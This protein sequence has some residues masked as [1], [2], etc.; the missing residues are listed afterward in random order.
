[1]KKTLTFSPFARIEG[2]LR[3]ELEIRDGH[4]AE[5]KSSGHLFRGFEWMVQGRE[6]LE[7]LVILCRICGQCSLAHSATCA[8]AL[9]NI[10]GITPPP[11]GLLANNIASAIE[12]ILSHLLHFYTSFAP[13][14]AQPPYDPT[15]T[16]RFSLASGTSQREA[17]RMRHEFLSLMGFFAGKWPN[18]LA[19]Q[20]GGTTRP[21]DTT[22]LLR[23]AGILN[24]FRAALEEQVLRGPIAQWLEIDSAPAL[25]NWLVDKN[26]CDSDLGVFITLARKHGLD[27]L[28]VGPRRFISSGGWSMGP[29]KTWLR[30]GFLDAD[31]HAEFKPQEITEDC[32]YAWY[33]APS[34]ASPLQE[35]GDPDPNRTEAY[36][37]AKA[38][39]YE[40]KSAEVGPMARMLSDGDPLA[41]NLLSRFGPSVMLRVIMRW[42]EVFRLVE[43]V[44]KWISE[45]NPDEPFYVKER[46]WDS[47]STSAAGITEAPRG[48]LGHWVEVE[49]GRIRNYQ[50]ITPTGWNFSPRDSLSNPGPLEEALV[51]T[52]INDEENP[53]TVSHVVRSFDPCLF[54]M[55]H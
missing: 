2:Q 45:I 25:D 10:Q 32:K 30:A 34:Q 26:H 41:T 54:C 14:L 50:V 5:A 38:P 31:S 11:N 17:L 48:T 51:G 42:H 46:P 47:F 35:H 49:K 44:G 24:G 8:A 27:K 18:S 21:L 12:T 43:Q 4:V 20:P 15:M 55:V 16:R 33:N 40:G 6:P 53:V 39:R 28:G 7:A 22:E 36:S 29:G 9:R 13:D 1:M 19:I 52:V 3:V 37:W 23:A